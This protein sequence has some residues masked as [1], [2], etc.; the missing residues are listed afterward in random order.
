[1]GG[2]FARGGHAV[3]TIKTGSLDLQVIHPDYGRPE[4]AAMAILTDV[5]GL[6]VVDRGSGSDDV[7]ALLVTGC[8]FPGCALETSTDMTGF[9]V[10]S[11][12]GADQ[13]EA[14]GQ[15]IK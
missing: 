12:M 9:A 8:A 1:M 4:I 5:A 10:G 7:T 15:V 13:F 14:G 11:Q 3:V 2:R 6:Y